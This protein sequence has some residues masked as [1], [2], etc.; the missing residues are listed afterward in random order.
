MNI[1]KILI[2]LFTLITH[3]LI[4]AQKN[5][6]KEILINNDIQFIKVEVLA[7]HNDNL[8]HMIGKLIKD[9][10]KIEDIASMIKKTIQE[11]PS[12]SSWNNIPENE[13]I[14][15]YINSAQLNINK[16]DS[17]LNPSTRPKL[18]PPV[19]KE[20][21]NNN[22]KYI[23]LNLITK[24]NDNLKK[25]I[26]DFSEN[27]NL[28]EEDISSILNN[29]LK[30]NKHITNWKNIPE[31]EK[32]IISFPADILSLSK[33]HSLINAFNQ[34][35]K[36]NQIKKEFYDQ[37]NIKFIKIN[38][39]T[40]KNDN[41]SN[42]VRTFTQKENSIADL[43]LIIKKTLKN[44][45][46]IKSWDNIQQGKTISLY[47]TS[48]NF[49]FNRPLIEALTMQREDSKISFELK[50]ESHLT[51]QDKE[52]YTKNNIK[53]IKIDMLTIKNDSLS[54]M[55]NLFIKES[56]LNTNI[57]P[58]IR[59][60]LSEN[61]KV[62]RWNKMKEGKKVSLYISAEQIDLKKLHSIVTRD[63]ENTKISL[64][65]ISLDNSFYRTN[66]IK[67][68][69][70]NIITKEYDNIF[71]IIQHLM[72]DQLNPKDT[73]P[74]ITK[75]LEN[76]RHVKSWN[77]MKAGVPIS[78]YL[79]ATSTD[80]SK[81]NPFIQKYDSTD[82]S[83]SISLKSK[84]YQRFSKR[85]KATYVGNIYY[86]LTSGMYY[87]TQGRSHLTYRQNSLK[88]LGGSLSY[89]NHTNFSY[90]LTGSFSFLNNITTLQSNDVK[91]NLNNLFVNF[92]TSYK[93]KRL[94]ISVYLGLDF[95]KTLTFDFEALLTYSRIFFD[96]NRML[97]LTFGILKSFKIKNRDLFL[98][99]SIAKSILSSRVS[100][101][102]T[103][104]NQSTYHGIKTFLYLFSP[105]NKRIFLQSYLKYHSLEGPSNIKILTG[106]IGL[107]FFL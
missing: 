100:E 67:F 31:N 58:I 27:K 79:D 42:L 64:Q 1:K 21:G 90:F 52:F 62:K 94:P 22:Y 68:I 104:Q 103:I 14:T 37:N 33:V 77:N 107:G 59:R 46:H 36:E 101:S 65:E 84:S 55:I 105:I 66:N 19:S 61:R 28:S 18:F 106:A 83:P 73:F 25:I 44:N 78:I 45:K 34:S 96:S 15:L 40:K 70:V 57:T 72:R 5:N 74:M 20:E 54:R 24:K 98:K 95:E 17:L 82:F 91:K 97:Y 80:L 51:H 41:L 92:T 38:V 71:Q 48:E 76:N 69:K 12:I 23:K 87:Q 50:K 53:F 35:K 56:N 6:L 7:K 102:P 93:F 88:T 30:N 63:K 11:N 26:E 4:S 89:Y 13:K 39:K 75:T 10:S 60:T 81:L 9:H 32:I 16:L 99:F 29:T 43:A 3:S 47:I 2:L 8:S 86:M 49:N 85:S